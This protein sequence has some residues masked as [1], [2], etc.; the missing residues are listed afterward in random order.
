MALR[1]L[2][3]VLDLRAKASVIPTT[4]RIYWC[5][6]QLARAPDITPLCGFGAK[7][8]AEPIQIA[9]ITM[10]HDDDMSAVLVARLR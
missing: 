3:G 1:G 9:R 6:R 8:M 2:G 7:N 10:K 5:V 4:A